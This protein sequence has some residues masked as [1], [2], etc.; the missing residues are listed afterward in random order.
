MLNTFKVW[1]TIPVVEL[2]RAVKFYSET[3]GLKTLW[4]EKEMGV[5]GMEAGGGT[6]VQLYQRAPSKADHTL[7]TFEVE[8]IEAVADGLRKA[9][10]HIEEYDSEFLKTVNG[11]ATMGSEKAC[12]FKDS[13]G[14]ILCLHE[15]IK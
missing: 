7:A 9:G 1:A 15:T 4:T 12:W 2:D 11:V 13:E 14:N 5:A 10:V 8:G 6:M 3:L